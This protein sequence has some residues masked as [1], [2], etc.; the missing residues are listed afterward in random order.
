[1]LLPSIFCFYGNSAKATEEYELA[2]KKIATFIN[3]SDSSEI[4]FTRNATEAI[5]LVAYSW[6]LQNLKADD[7][8]HFLI[9]MDFISLYLYETLV[10][11]FFIIFLNEECNVSLLFLSL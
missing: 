11:S 3:A 6:G 9:S 1:M 7:E 4:V 2:R 5:N 10:T 8:V